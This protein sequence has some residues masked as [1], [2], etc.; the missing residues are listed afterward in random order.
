MNEGQIRDKLV[1]SIRLSSK[2]TS[3]AVMIKE[4]DFMADQVTLWLSSAIKADKSGIKGGYDVESLE[5]VLDILDQCLDN[6]SRIRF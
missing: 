1:S 6:L 5:L 2:Y 4:I 3:L